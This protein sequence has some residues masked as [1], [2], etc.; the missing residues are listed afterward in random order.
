MSKLRRSRFY[1]RDAGRSQSGLTVSV[2]FV[3]FGVALLA[4]PYRWHNTPAYGN[5]LAIADT[6]IWGTAYLLVAALMFIYL[7]AYSP[8]W[9]AILAHTAIFALS[10][11]WLVAFVIRY[12]TDDGTTIVNV[13]SWS[14]YTLL[15]AYSALRIDESSYSRTLT[16]DHG[17]RPAS[18]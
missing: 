13:G 12:L 14:V 7:F 15:I 10:A 6:R 8:G 1:F 3:V 11:S 17:D 9:F 16:N 2:L 5:L 18:R 4:Q